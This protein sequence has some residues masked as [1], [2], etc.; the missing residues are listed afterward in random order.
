[1]FQ[2]DAESDL[3][4]ELVAQYI[5]V[6]FCGEGARSAIEDGKRIARISCWKLW[7]VG[8]VGLLRGR[9][10]GG[11]DGGG[12]VL[13]FHWYGKRLRVHYCNGLSSTAGSDVALLKRT[14]VERKV[15]VLF[16]LCIFLGFGKNKILL[17]WI[18]SLSKVI[19]VGSVDDPV[20]S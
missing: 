17:S 3:L 20:S 10:G 13:R 4:F 7:F 19:L 18:S 2:V 5:L 1:M 6:H 16:L 15:K 14:Q 12:G 9:R 11:C 8:A